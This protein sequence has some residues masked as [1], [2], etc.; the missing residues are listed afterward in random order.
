MTTTQIIGR[1]NEMEHLSL[2]IENGDHVLLTG[3]W[4]RGKS[5]LVS[6]LMDSLSGQ[7]VTPVYFNC[8][9]GYS[10]QTFLEQYSKQILKSMSS[11]VKNLFEDSQKYLPNIRPKISINPAQGVDIKIDYHIGRKDIKQYLAEAIDVPNRIYQNTGEKMVIILDEYHAFLEVKD[12]GISELIAKS[13]KP[14]VSYVFTSSKAKEIDQILPKKMLSKIGIK[15]RLDLGKIPPNILYFYLENSFKDHE[16]KPTPAVIDKILSSMDGEI[17]FIN[18]LLA[19]LIEKGRFFKRVSL[20]DISGAIREIVGLREDLFYQAFSSLSAHQK[21]LINALAREGGMQIFKGEFIY[22]NG[23][24]SVP[25][26][27][28]SVS[29]LIKKNFIH[30][31]NGEYL[32]TNILFREWLKRNFL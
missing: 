10:E 11:K 24:V 23:L 5:Y 14:G 15:S 27:Q 20:M 19:K 1:D 30:K 6:S 9:N 25:S 2:A 4:Y 16:I 12:L 7:N 13:A 8:M 29:A 17:A 26:V 32:I 31:E 21:G 3:P 22:Q 28:T 18:H